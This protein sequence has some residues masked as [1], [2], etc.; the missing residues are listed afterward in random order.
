MKRI[1]AFVFCGLALG[2]FIQPGV[3]LSI[4]FD[5]HVF[6]NGA[7]KSTPGNELVVAG[8]VILLECVPSQTCDPFNL[9]NWSDIIGFG[10]N[11]PAPQVPTR[12]FRLLSDREDN[13]TNCF[14][15]EFGQGT[16]CPTDHLRD[17]VFFMVEGSALTIHPGDHVYRIH[18]DVPSSEGEGGSQDAQP[19]IYVAAAGSTMPGAPIPEPAT[20]LLLGSGL[21]GLAAWRKVRK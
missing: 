12:L 5:I 2:F 15:D 17:N 11:L 10:P 6:E 7:P 9:R 8:A 4:G 3:A 13:L 20:M 14:I 1:I 19:T 21:V 18:S 16:V